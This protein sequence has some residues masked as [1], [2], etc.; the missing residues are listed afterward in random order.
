MTDHVESV[1]QQWKRERPDLDVSPMAVVGRV[2]RVARRFDA[3]L[4]RTFAGHNLDAAAFDVLATLRRHGSPY[5]LSP[6]DLTNGAMVTSSAI[7]QR[8]NRLEVQ[9]LIARSPSSVDG[10]GKNVVLTDL[11]R[12]TVDSA[13]PDH[14]RTENELLDPLDDAERQTLAALLAKLDVP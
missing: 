7:A 13:L 5:T 14:L 9:G 4:G 1:L 11:G 3:R 8:L 6:K 12:T 2:S 10:R